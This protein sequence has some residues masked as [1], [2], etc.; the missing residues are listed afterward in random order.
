MIKTAVILLRPADRFA[1]GCQDFAF[2]VMAVE[3]AIGRTGGRENGGISGGLALGGD[4]FLDENE[5]VFFHASFGKR[6]D[7]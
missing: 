6:R 5:R 4:L 7:P 2:G 3:R 1:M